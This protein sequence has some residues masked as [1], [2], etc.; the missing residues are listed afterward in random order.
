[1]D[2]SPSE[3]LA[4]LK[5]LLTCNAAI[6]FLLLLLTSLTAVAADLR[7]PVFIKTTCDAKVSSAVLTSLRNEMSTSQKYRLAHNL[8]DGDQMG[9]VLTVNMSCTERN[10][11]AA[12]ATVFGRA[13]CFGV[14]NCHLSID[15]STIKSDLCEVS[16]AAEC[17]RTLFKAFDDYMSNP[18]GPPLR[19][20]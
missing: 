19:L 9:V 20:Q 16:S 2:S 15:G 14:T 10:D 5:L 13:K 17:G 18:L 4:R 6:L 3:W 7:K 1:M 12:I 11:I 8:A